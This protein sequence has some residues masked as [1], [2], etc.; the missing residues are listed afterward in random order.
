MSNLNPG[1]QV[2]LKL[3]HQ[4]LWNDVGTIKEVDHERR[5]YVVETPDGTYV[6]NRKHIQ[7]IKP[8]VASTQSVEPAET[9]SRPEIKIDIPSQLSNTSTTDKPSLS[10]T[11]SDNVQTTR[12]GRTVQK[13]KRLDDYET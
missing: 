5:Q 7:N 3:D 4:K 1:D 11:T 6:R 2:R 13:P 9:T 8:S 10:R 12:S